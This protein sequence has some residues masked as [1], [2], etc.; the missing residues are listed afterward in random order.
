M[1]L[2]GERIFPK[3]SIVEPRLAGKVIGM[4][5]ELD[6]AQLLVLAN[7]SNACY[8]KIIQFANESSAALKAAQKKRDNELIEGYV[9]RAM[10]K[11]CINGYDIRLNHIIFMYY[12]E[13][14]DTET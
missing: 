13:Q 4:L 9:K 8:R 7:D 3:L 11:Y 6:Q 12:H 10:D 5:I 2:V 1:K 14:K